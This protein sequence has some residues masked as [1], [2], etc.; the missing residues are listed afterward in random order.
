MDSRRTRERNKSVQCSLI[1]VSP[2]DLA[3]S[4]AQHTQAVMLPGSAHLTATRFVPPPHSPLWPLS[5]LPLLRRSPS[6]AESTWGA[7]LSSSVVYYC[8]RTGNL[9]SLL[10]AGLTILF[11][12][13]KRS[14]YDLLLIVHKGR[15]VRHDRL[16]CV[17]L[18]CSQRTRRLQP[19]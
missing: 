17:F 15:A 3:C 7:W 8:A 4:P 12:N 13:F 10:L 1:A 2:R 18:L 14:T 16:G 5:S 9:S 11:L 19:Q 6:L